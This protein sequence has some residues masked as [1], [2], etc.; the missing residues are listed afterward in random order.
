MGK[1]GGRWWVAESG[2]VSQGCRC[3]L[4]V[5]VCGGGGTPNNGFSAALAGE[6]DGGEKNN[7]KTKQPKAGGLAG[8]VRR[9]DSSRKRVN[10]GDSS[11]SNQLDC[12]AWQ[13]RGHVW[14]WARAWTGAVA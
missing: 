9:D 4:K 11:I 7:K 14:A 10:T 8:R 13:E 6:P 1:S 3:R 5:E 12:W 2:G